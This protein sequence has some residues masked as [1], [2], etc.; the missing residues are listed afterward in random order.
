MLGVNMACLLCEEQCV[1]CSHPLTGVCRMMFWLSGVKTVFCNC[2]CK[3][4]SFGCR[5]VSHSRFGVFLSDLT[6]CVGNII[7]NCR[8]ES[9]L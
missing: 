2:K 6:I 5:L 4:K 9:A 7:N 3:Q 8:N 1:R